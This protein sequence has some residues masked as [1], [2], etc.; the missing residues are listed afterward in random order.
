MYSVYTSVSDNCW[1][2][3]SEQNQHDFKMSGTKGKCIEARELVIALPEDFVKL[4]PDMLLKLFT[5][6]FH[7][8]YGVPCISALH[9]NKTKTNYHI[10]LIY[11]ER[12]VKKEPVKKVASRNMFYDEKG[13][14]VRTKKEILDADGNIRSG[15]YIIHKGHV[16][17]LRM[18]D[19]K[20][21]CFKADGFLDKVKEMY[22]GLINELLPD[23]QQMA[24][25]D[26]HGPYL[27]TKKIGK[28]NPMEAVIKADNEMRQEWNQT[29]DRAIVTGVPE[30]DIVKIKQ[31]QI[32]ETTGK[33]IEDHGDRPELFAAIIG[34]AIRMLESLIRKVFLETNKEEDTVPAVA[35]KTVEIDSARPSNP[36][37]EERYRRMETI[38]RSL[39]RKNARIHEMEDTII[40]CNKALEAY[41][42][43]W[44]LLKHK[45]IEELRNK[46]SN[47]ETDIKR[48]KTELSQILTDNGYKNARE[49]YQEYNQ[50]KIEM[51]QLLA[52]KKAWDDAHA[53]PSEAK[54]KSKGIHKRLEQNKKKISNQKQTKTKTVNK[55]REEL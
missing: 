12:K 2:L 29:V 10:H 40:S 46:I 21:S 19:A 45:E 38:R 5:E 14:H 44:K 9:H 24:V 20:E 32:K 42:G 26:S 51:E 28:N 31:E 17:D 47:C 23:E 35:D 27:P 33:S 39:S 16:Y 25:F 4:D 37:L 54:S 8:T 50:V 11:S 36:E 43:I 34:M 15:C 41:T 48:L 13:K 49:F 53:E 18:F 6:Q 1:E 55:I 22:C 3:L 52:E 7:I 30:E